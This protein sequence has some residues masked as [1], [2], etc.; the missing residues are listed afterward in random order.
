[1]LILR[2]IIVIERNRK[3]YDKIREQYSKFY[4]NKYPYIV[5]SSYIDF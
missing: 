3:H 1:M 2:L 5:F 4:K